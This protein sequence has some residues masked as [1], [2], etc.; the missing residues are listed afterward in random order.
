MGGDERK[1]IQ[2][3]VVRRVPL[4][5]MYGTPSPTMA[6]GREIQRQ[7]RDRERERES[8]T[9]RESWGASRKYSFRRQERQIMTTISSVLFLS[10]SP[11]C[12]GAI[13]QK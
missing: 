4:K 1:L 10:V 8:E 6:R 12:I 13:K 3:N 5:E 2:H 11:W 9:G 7:D